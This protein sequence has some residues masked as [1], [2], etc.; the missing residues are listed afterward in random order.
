MRRDS[1]LLA[2]IVGAI[3]RILEITGSASPAEIEETPDQRDALLWNFT[4]LGEAANQVST[5]LKSQSPELPWADASRTRNRIVHGGMA[6]G[7]STSRC[8]PRSPAATSP[9]SSLV[10]G[11]TSTQYPTRTER[12]DA[13]QP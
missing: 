12:Y 13:A 10:S 5:E 7:R 4:V 6:T 3:E 11:R 9:P 1:V 8:S 2:E